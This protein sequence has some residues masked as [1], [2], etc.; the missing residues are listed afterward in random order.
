[1]FKSKKTLITIVISFIFVGLT[2]LS[3][4]LEWGQVAVIAFLCCATLSFCLLAIF[5]FKDKRKI[6]ERKRTYPQ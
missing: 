1:M 5:Y 3:R 4:N 2:S 6:S